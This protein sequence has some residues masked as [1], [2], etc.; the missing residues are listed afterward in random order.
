MKNLFVPYEITLALIELGF[1][2]DDCIARFVD[3]GLGFIPKLD[4]PFIANTPA[5]LWQEAIAFLLNKLENTYPM[6]KIK[7]YSDF[8]G[9]WSEYGGM[10][11]DFNTLEEAILKGIK[12][13]K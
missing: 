5:P 12:L 7:I 13:C 4:D 10:E 8:S 1:C 3:E 2:G 9:D 6:L 11:E